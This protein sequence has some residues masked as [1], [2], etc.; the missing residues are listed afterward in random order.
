MEREVW[1]N[2]DARV[3]FIVN[4]NSQKTE[5]LAVQLAATQGKFCDI[6]SMTHRL[7]T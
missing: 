3:K 2:L 5:E 4:E 1:D 6:Y 7:T